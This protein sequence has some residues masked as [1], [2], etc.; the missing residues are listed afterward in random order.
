M[1]T[2]RT[3]TYQYNDL[4]SMRKAVLRHIAVGKLH[5]E[6]MNVF[7]FLSDFCL[8]KE[9]GQCHP[10][11][12]KIAEAIGLA[13]KT[14]SKI[15]QSLMAVGVLKRIQ[16]GF[17]NKRM[18]N[19]IS[20]DAW[21]ES[22]RTHPSRSTRTHPPESTRT[23]PLE[24]ESNYIESLTTGF[25]QK[26]VTSSR[27][28]DNS[29][30]SDP[31]GTVDVESVGMTEHEAEGIVV[32]LSP[33]GRIVPILVKEQ[34]IKLLMKSDITEAMAAEILIGESLEVGRG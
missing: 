28:S 16:V 33:K 2:S 6:A 1:S 23:T 22:A 21:E 27:P 12:D 26:E 31:H 7:C 14:V 9:S 30:L 10:S 8:H 25:E 29:D 34:V 13:R 24:G 32:E 19:F 4:E 11:Y 18:I 15:M 5:R 3:Y 17:T 20:P